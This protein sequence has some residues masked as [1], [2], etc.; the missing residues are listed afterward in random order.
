MALRRR[1][2]GGVDGLFRGDAVVA[3]T[4]T[5]ACCGLSLA[6]IPRDVRR[7]QRCTRRPV[8][9]G[10]VRV[11]L[12]RYQRNESAVTPGQYGG[13][14]F[15]IGGPGNPATA[16][17]GADGPKRLPIPACNHSRPRRRRADLPGGANVVR[18]VRRSTL[19]PRGRAC[20][21]VV[22]STA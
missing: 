19:S 4:E 2:R 8:S 7:P 1:V 18:L 10:P 22:W 13:C 21:P 5:L 3:A 11:V 15:W 17:D 20:S 14:M 9:S 12:C 6:H 16:T